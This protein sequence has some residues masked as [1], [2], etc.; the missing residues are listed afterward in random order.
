MVVISE[1]NESAGQREGHSHSL[2]SMRKRDWIP[3]TRI[4]RK[5]C[6]AREGSL[7]I[8]GQHEHR[9]EEKWLTASTSSAAR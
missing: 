3:P 1:E 5:R 6:D 7:N 4:C 8:R 9:A 2:T